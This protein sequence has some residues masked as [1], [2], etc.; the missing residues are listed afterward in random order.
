MYVPCSPQ[1]PS[2]EIGLTKKE[3]SRRKQLIRFGFQ[4][5]LTI[6]GQMVNFQAL[7][8]FR[9]TGRRLMLGRHVS[10]VPY[11]VKHLTQQM[12]SRCPRL[13]NPICLNNAISSPLLGFAY[14]VG[15]PGH[16]ARPVLTP[17]FGFNACRVYGWI[18]PITRV[19]TKFRPY[20]TT[21]AKSP[22][23]IANSLLRRNLGS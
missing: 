23:T 14:P 17:H 3:A 10:G 16:R 18:L 22:L 13:S 21:N 5:V 8:S 6:E 1:P 4:S 20:P 2:E 19:L 7:R 11:T 15:Y 12:L 9:G